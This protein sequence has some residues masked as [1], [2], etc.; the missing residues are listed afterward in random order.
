MFTGDI[1]VLNIHHGLYQHCSDFK[2]LYEY[3]LD[4][5]SVDTGP[6]ESAA[7]VLRSRRSYGG[8]EPADT[9]KSVT[10]PRKN[11][12]FYVIKL[13]MITMKSKNTLFFILSDFFL[14]H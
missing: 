4:T 7:P 5:G 2:N 11:M 9:D 14:I 1:K 6:A 8:T 3:L 12:I 10:G 13:S